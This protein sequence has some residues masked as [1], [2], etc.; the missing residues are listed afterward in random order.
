[1]LEPKFHV[2]NSK[3]K[4]LQNN[5]TF[6][7]HEVVDVAS[8]YSGVGSYLTA[9]FKPPGQKKLVLKISKNSVEN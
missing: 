1:M 2:S 5:G 6:I 3:N 8:V 7:L 9:L 4:D